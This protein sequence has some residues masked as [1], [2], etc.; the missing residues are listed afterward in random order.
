MRMWNVLKMGMAVLLVL[1]VGCSKSDS[2]DDGREESDAATQRSSD[3]ESSEADAPEN[4]TEDARTEEAALVGMEMDPDTISATDTAMTDEYVSVVV[5]MS[6]FEEPIESYDIL[7]SEN[8]RSA[9]DGPDRT[10]TVERDR[11][12]VDG[13]PMS[14]FEGMSPGTYHLG[15]TVES[16]TDSATEEEL[17]T[18]ELQE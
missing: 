8:E 14:W 18:F 5:E 3:G 16:A 7:I 17:G 9:P 10:E 6:G 12:E 4:G 13:I 15:A 1:L 11:I 2:G